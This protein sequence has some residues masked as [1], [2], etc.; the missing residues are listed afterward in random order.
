MVF[1]EGVEP[2]WLGFVDRAPDPPAGTKTQ[3]FK[4]GIELDLSRTG[5]VLGHRSAGARL[6]DYSRGGNRL[7]P[8]HHLWRWRVTIP[9]RQACKAQLWPS[10]IPSHNWVDMLGVEPNPVGYKPTALTTEL[11][12]H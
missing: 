8:D 6:P 3:Y 7:Q 11:H 12:V 4:P 5:R 2:T 9:R 1:L 10:S